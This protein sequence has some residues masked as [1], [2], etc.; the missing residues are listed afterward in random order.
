MHFNWTRSEGFQLSQGRLRHLL[1]IGQRLNNSFVQMK[2][3]NHSRSFQ[4]AA[5]FRKLLMR[6]NFVCFASN[7][8]TTLIIV[9]IGFEDWILFKAFLTTIGVAGIFDLGGGPKPQITCNVVIRNFQKKNFLWG[10]D[11]V[12]WKI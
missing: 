2:L 4:P 3:S 7:V 11:I 1:K 8:N 10:K 9:L 6:S 12:E 5:A